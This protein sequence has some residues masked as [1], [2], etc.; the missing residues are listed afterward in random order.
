MADRNNDPS[1]RINPTKG[2]P[3]S[4]FAQDTHQIKPDEHRIHPLENGADPE[5]AK[6]MDRDAEEYSK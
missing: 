2:N 1:S 4:S 6:R 3:T 5:E